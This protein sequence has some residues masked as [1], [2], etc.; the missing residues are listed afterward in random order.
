MNKQQSPQQGDLASR[1]AAEPGAFSAP[2]LATYLGT[3]RSTIYER[4]SA[5]LIPHF[6]IGSIIRFDPAVIAQWLRDKEVK[7]A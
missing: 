3:S 2:K 5:G 7:A 4:A 6:R 1:I